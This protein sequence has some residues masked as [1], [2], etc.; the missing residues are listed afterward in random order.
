MI[1]IN[2]LGEEATTDNSGL[3]YIAGYV[4]SLIILLFVGFTLY[5]SVNASVEEQTRR[6]QSLEGQLAKL[7]VVTKEVRELETKKIELKQKLAVIAKLK[8]NKIGP[9][10]VMDD[11][12]TAVPE[13]AW[14]TE[15]REKENFLSIYGMALDDQTVATFMRELSKSTYFSKVELVESKKTLWKGVKIS[16]FSIETVINYAGNLVLATPTAV[17]QDGAV[18]ES[19]SAKTEKQ[20]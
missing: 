16:Q 4:G 10:R 17:V 18:V 6:V 7:K 8:R 12:N 3:Y 14:I 9:V 2:L 19:S 20:E 1:K 11:L 13:K 15:I 5:S